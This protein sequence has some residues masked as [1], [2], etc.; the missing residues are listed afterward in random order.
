MKAERWFLSSL[1][2]ALP[3]IKLG[4]AVV[5]IAAIAWQAFSAAGSH[6]VL[7]DRVLHD[8]AD[9]AASEFVRRS[10]AYFGNYGFAVLSRAL[11]RTGKDAA[12]PLPSRADLIA[13]IPEN[14]RGSVELIRAVIRFDE[15]G[16][17]F[18][19]S[20]DPLPE[21]IQESLIKGALAPAGDK[22][23]YSVVHSVKDGRTRTFVVARANG[24]ARGDRRLAFEVDYNALGAWMNKYVLKDP[25]LPPAL[26]SRDS[27]ASA[28]HVDVQPPGPA[29]PFDSPPG[30]KSL[31]ATVVREVVGDDPARPLAGFF[32]RVTIDP[33]A[34]EQLIIGGRPES[35]MPLLMLLL[36]LAIA[37]MIAAALQIRRERKLA[38]L[39]Q[40]FVTQASHELRTPVARARMFTETL[41]L[42]RVRS[43]EE[44]QH[45]LR[46]IDRSTRQLSLLIENMLQ[47]SRRGG[48]GVLPV[49]RVDLPALAREV[50]S[51]FETSIGTSATHTLKTPPALDAIVNPDAFRQVLLNLLDN[52]WKYGGPSK[53][54]TIELLVVDGEIH[55]RIDDSGP[56]V[57]ERDRES[58]W[59]PYVRL[60]RD[61]RSSTAGSG[62]GLAVVRD[63]IAKHGG[64]YWIDA[65]PQGGARF[66]VTFPVQPAGAL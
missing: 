62:I 11:D 16:T 15:H 28:L 65:S 39:R 19:T 43:D 44:R 24:P 22:V 33:S 3:L 63:L 18:E 13:V 9:L 12:A 40:D 58:I 55:V 45:A 36:A 23:E 37:L 1:V 48:D 38:Q 49:E 60:D 2:D 7:A 21:A 54:T 52:A 26:A 6:Q 30:H 4:V 64:R 46:A 41:L 27:S 47:F 5:L 66:V 59:L 10:E 25:L 51:E 32:V 50:I 35:R 34:A 20:G 17:R 14:S 53:A 8:Y 61:R 57:P 42:D 31:G 56:G 29:A